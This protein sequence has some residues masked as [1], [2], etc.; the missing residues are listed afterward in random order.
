M[1]PPRKRS[2][3][4]RTVIFVAIERRC[5]RIRLCL[6]LKRLESLM[7]WQTRHNRL[8]LRQNAFNRHPS[9][10]KMATHKLV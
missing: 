6:D 10:V 4:K 7:I 8:L 5:S 2:C 1:T 3:R 9:V